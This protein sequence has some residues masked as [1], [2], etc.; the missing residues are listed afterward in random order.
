[1]PSGISQANY[2]EKME[3]YLFPFLRAL[4]ALVNRLFPDF[5]M[6]IP[7]ISCTLSGIFFKGLKELQTVKGGG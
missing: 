3:S 1:L 7:S 2:T 6:N 5:V 4:I